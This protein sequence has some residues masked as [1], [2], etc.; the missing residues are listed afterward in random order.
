[1]TYCLKKKIRLSPPIKT[2]C[3]PTD[4]ILWSAVIKGFDKRFFKSMVK[5]VRD[6]PIRLSIRVS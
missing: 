3:V 4:F 2:N 6:I 1:M 5:I